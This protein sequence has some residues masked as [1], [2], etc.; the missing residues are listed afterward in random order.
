MEAL[1]FGGSISARTGFP[2]LGLGDDLVAAFKK[3]TF[4]SASFRFRMLWLGVPP[5][6]KANEP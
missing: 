1:M 2:L 5:E 4:G 3:I 6:P